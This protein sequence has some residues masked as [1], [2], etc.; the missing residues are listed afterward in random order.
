LKVAITGPYRLTAR[1]QR[2]L[3]ELTVELRRLSAAQ[4]LIPLSR[5]V[6][7]R[8]SPK[9]YGEALQSVG[10]LVAERFHCAVA[11]VAS[12]IPNEKAL[13]TYAREVK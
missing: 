10:N 12:F 3:P 2:K 13:T 6:P 4:G 8:P 11:R 9:G 5:I 7:A 1:S